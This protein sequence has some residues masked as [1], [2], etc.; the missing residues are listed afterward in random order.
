[1]MG[2]VVDSSGKIELP[3]VI[4][5]TSTHR[6]LSKSVTAAIPDFRFEPAQERG[7]TVCAFMLQPYIFNLRR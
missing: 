5:F 1:M 4:T 7:K 3:S 2:F 6:A